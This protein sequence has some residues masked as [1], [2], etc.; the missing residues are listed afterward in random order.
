MKIK[1]TA[2]FDELSGKT[3]DFI[4]EININVWNGRSSVQTVVRGIM[5]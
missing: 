1:L 2:A 4:A 5:D 3:I